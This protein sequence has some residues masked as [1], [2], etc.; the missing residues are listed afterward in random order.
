VKFGVV[1]EMLREA[2][3]IEMAATGHYARVDSDGLYTAVDASKDQSYFLYGICRDDL[4]R[5]RF[6][7]GG[8]SKSETRKQAASL[9]L[10]IADRK[11]SV[12]LCFADQGDYRCALGDC[13]DAG[14]GD[15]VDVAGNRL[16]RHDGI[17]RYTIGQR[18]GLGIAARVPLYVIEIDPVRN[19][20][21][22][23]DRAA[24]GSRTV[25]AERLNILAPDLLTGTSRLFGKI[26]SRQ[27]AA[28]CSAVDYTSEHLVV[29]FA[30]PQHGVTPGQHLV[31]YT[32]SGQVVGGGEIRGGEAVRETVPR[33]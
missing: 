30:E 21:V 25:C 2:F 17:S 23:G 12:E 16:G 1:M 8:Q 32:A 22:L 11:E 15:V 4:A 14:P 31:L 18:E 24:A 29:E 19:T 27:P 13:P 7:L 28:E 3:G 26:R 9:G 6:P 20:I 33:V 5:V 10:S